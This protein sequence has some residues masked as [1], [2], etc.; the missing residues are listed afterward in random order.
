MFNATD[1]DDRNA[2]ISAINVGETFT[3]ANLKNVKL[4]D[5]DLTF[6]FGKGNT[7]HKL[8]L[9]YDDEF[10]H[11]W[12]FWPHENK[13]KAKKGKW[14]AK[15]MSIEQFNKKM[16]QDESAEIE[17]PLLEPEGSKSGSS[18]QTPTSDAPTSEAPKTRSQILADFEKEIEE[19]DW[20]N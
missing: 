18:A 2:A 11:V 6:T 16:G 4:K 12:A 17:L 14:N 19:D 3:K 15:R 8:S 20:F 5:G 7:E 1:I 9:Y 10:G 13:A